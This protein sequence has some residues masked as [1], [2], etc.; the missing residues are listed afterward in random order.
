MKKN[1]TLT[2]K[3]GSIALSM[4]IVSSVVAGGLALIAGPAVAAGDL[5]VNVNDESGTAIDGAEVVIYDVSDDSEVANGTTSS[6]SYTA[7]GL[8]DGDYYAEVTADGYAGAQSDQVTISGAAASVTV[9]LADSS[10]VVNETVSVENTTLT[11]YGEIETTD[12]I[13]EIGNTTSYEWTFHGVDS[14][15]NE[16]Q[17]GSAERFVGEGTV[18]T[19][20]V[21]LNDSQTTEYDSVRVVVEGDPSYVNSSEAG[22]T[23]EVS[24]GGGS[25]GIGGIVNATI[26]GIPIVLLGGAAVLGYVLMER[27]E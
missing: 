16:T 20:E 13:N 4:L 5:T 21:S 25:S 9:N 1:N 15:G 7:S 19:E 14:G 6:G 26:F 3:I 24:G 12:S 22:T 11:A 18:A 27:D 8:S 23:A 10:E 17:I 2:S